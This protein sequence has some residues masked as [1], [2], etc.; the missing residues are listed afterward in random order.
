MNLLILDQFSHAGGAQL[1]LRDLMPEMKGRR[2][3]IVLMAPGEGELTRWCRHSNIPVYPLPLGSYPSGGRS[4]T[5][6]LRYSADAARSVAAIKA[7]IG[8][9]RID[10]IYINGPRIL[11]CL[12]N[13]ARPTVFHAHSIVTSPLGRRLAAW[14]LR[15]M[16]A[17]TI[18]ASRLVAE[19]YGKPNA[20]Q[21][22][23]IYNG[24]PDTGFEMRSF[25]R[26]PAR[27]GMIGRIAPEKGN[28]DFVRAGRLIRNAQ[29]F[30]Y[31]ASLHSD[32]E[33]A[34]RVRRM[35]EGVPMEFR[36]WTNDVAD[37]FRNIDVLAV[38]STAVEAST[39]VIMEAFA[40][41]TPVVAY[42]SGGIPEIIENDRTG[43]LTKTADYRLL[44]REICDLLKDPHR[45]RMLAAAGRIEWE[46]RFTVNAFR[47]R[48]CS[49]IES[50]VKESCFKPR[51]EVAVQQAG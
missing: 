19:S 39:R 6:C 27:I 11:P 37:A 18:A 29:F 26:R 45:M 33:Y 42:P 23:V 22:R 47:N 9:C 36:G 41:G 15:H 13:V 50:C 28:V 32:P 49:F 7:V 14:C 16:N 10:A 2:W 51:A 38:P 8:E 17:R 4:F 40:A 12:L 43:V 21:F 34:A 31:G 46:R 30:V 48:I 44:A 3:N 35:A 5:D 25:L 24:V 20:F 1:C